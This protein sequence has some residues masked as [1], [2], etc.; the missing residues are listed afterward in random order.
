MGLNALL[1][2]INYDSDASK[3][4]RA[5]PDDVMAK[6]YDIST[7]VPAIVLGIMALILFFGYDLS[8]KKLE[9]MRAQLAEVRKNEE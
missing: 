4:G 5:L 3:Y 8:K 2:L 7:L 9:E 6:L 1:A